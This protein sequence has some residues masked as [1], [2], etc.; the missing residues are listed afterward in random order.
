MNLASADSSKNQETLSDVEGHFTFAD[1]SSGAFQFSITA[2]GFA[3]QVFS[4]ILHANEEFNAPPI[5]LALATK[6]I[7]VQAI[8]PTEL[9]EEQIKEQEKQRVLGF[10][11]NFYATYV[12]NPAPMNSKQKF[13]LAWKSTLDPA[14]FALTGVLAGVQ[15][16][17]NDFREY[18]Q[19][20]QGFGKRYGALYADIVTSTFVGDALLPSLLKQD[21]RYFYKG[22]GKIHSRILYAI[23][24]SVICKGDNGN[25][26][27]N[28]SGILGG[29][30]AGGV[31][32]LYYPATNRSRVELTF[33]NAAFRIGTTAATNLIQEFIVRKLTWTFPKHHPANPNP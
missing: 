33:T 23:A 4:G 7:E 25:W 20:L 15:Q 3:T 14:T 16:A 6:S 19:G 13:E 28:F 12:H 32:N 31:S 29:V 18:G 30:A 11:P 9:A 22:V 5:Q 26:Q 10:I 21:P 17:H 8:S 24:N 2:D 1:I 27:A